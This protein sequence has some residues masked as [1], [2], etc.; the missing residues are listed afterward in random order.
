MRQRW[1]APVP[2]A[3]NPGLTEKEWVSV[4]CFYP[5]LTEKEWVSVSC[6]L[7]LVSVS[8]FCF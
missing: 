2:C 1:P 8:C 7:F 4:S 6:F 5:G 3:P